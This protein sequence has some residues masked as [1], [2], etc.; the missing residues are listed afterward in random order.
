MISCER[1]TKSASLPA[2]IDPFTFS[3]NVAY[4]LFTVNK[5]RASA[6]LIFYSGP[7][8]MPSFVLR[9]T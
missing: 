1:T 9:V 4:A 2:S 8:S 5:R 7:S 3:S 6:R